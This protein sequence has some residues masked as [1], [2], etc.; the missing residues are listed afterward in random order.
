L[1]PACPSAGPT[2]GAGVA[3]PPEIWSFNFFVMFLAIFKIG[4]L[5]IEFGTRNEYRSNI[6]SLVPIVVDTT[7]FFLYRQ[8]L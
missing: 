8:G 4:I 1:I 7:E 3:L 6:L 5:N 2:G